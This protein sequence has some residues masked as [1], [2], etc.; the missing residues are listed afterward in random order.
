M[1]R[2]RE[3]KSIFFQEGLHLNQAR[4][5][6]A[7]PLRR[8]EKIEHGLTFITSSYL[9]YAVSQNLFGLTVLASYQQT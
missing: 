1:R 4:F 8:A 7:P 9:I 6:G 3:P 2:K 5:P